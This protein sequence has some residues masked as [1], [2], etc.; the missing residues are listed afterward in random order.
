MKTLTS[1]TDL[2]ELL[3]QF[4]FEYLINQRRVS[5]HTVASY[6][7]SF[8]LLLSFVAHS[9]KKSLPKLMM[10]DL[11]ANMIIHFLHY[12]EQDRDNSISTR[13]SRLAAIRSF[14]N[15]AS[16]QLPAG[17]PDIQKV[18]SIP[19]KLDD[20]SMIV[21]LDRDEITAIVNAPNQKT[22]SGYRDHNLL[23]TL[24]NTGA[25]VSEITRLQRQDVDLQRQHAI[26]LHGKGRKERIIPLWQ[27]TITALHAWIK[28]IP[29]EPATPLFP[30]RFGETLNRSGVRQRLD[31]AVRMA[32]T[33]CPS[34][35]H[36]KI[37]PHT[38][39]HTTALHLLQSGVALSVIALWLG[40]EQIGT[41]HQYMEVNLEMKKAAIDALPPIMTNKQH[42]SHKPSEG[43]IAF[44][45]SL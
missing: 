35:L 36:Q 43:I 31:N 20:H 38:I 44:L 26:H 4:F 1:T 29:D 21:C 18:L 28:R 13:N 41:T 7:D 23:L 33:T 32:A 5:P 16:T 9:R 3:Q 42:D 15:F 37:S 40:H 27:Q 8:L 2:G 6:R 25:R 19:Q 14:F 12:L 22:W 45:E 10:A 30:N 24:Y 34:L 17:L 39:R 11:D